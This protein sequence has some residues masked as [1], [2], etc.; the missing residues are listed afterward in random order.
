MV[1]CFRGDDGHLEKGEE[2]GFSEGSD[3]E[4]ECEQASSLG[5]ENAEASYG[6]RE[7]QE[8]LPVLKIGSVIA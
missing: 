2:H 3:Y 1:E 4:S 5:S 7:G 6:K 8:L